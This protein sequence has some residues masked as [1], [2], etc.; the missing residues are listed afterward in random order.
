LSLTATDELYKMYPD[1]DW[2]YDLLSSNN[3]IS[4]DIIIKYGY[5]PWNL[6]KLSIKINMKH[7]FDKYDAKIKKDLTINIIYIILQNS[8]A[9]SFSA[10]CL[11]SASPTSSSSSKLAI[12]SMKS[13][14]SIF[15]GF[16]SLSEKRTTTQ[17][18]SS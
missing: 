15:C 5:K 4:E 16:E 7:R 14:I 17:L 2:D 13:F 6:I 11:V 9:S 8:S 1:A 3:N 12:N 10:Y 18:Y